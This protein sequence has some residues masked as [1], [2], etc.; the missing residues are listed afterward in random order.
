MKEEQQIAELLR[1]QSRW[2]LS[3]SD[4]VKRIAD[5]LGETPATWQ[6]RLANWRKGDRTAPLQHH[7][8]PGKRPFYYDQD[9]D[10]FINQ[11]LAARA[12]YTGKAPQ[13]AS[14]KVIADQHG[15]VL[16][17][18]S[19]AASGRLRVNL[20]TARTLGTQLIAL[21]DRYAEQVQ[22]E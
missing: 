18:T 16:E 2:P 6:Q 19:P 5:A 4:T 20:S 10:A 1:E 7:Q 17:W 9:V 13:L 12:A 3:V 11:R 21:A 14:A 8:N 15:I 22:G